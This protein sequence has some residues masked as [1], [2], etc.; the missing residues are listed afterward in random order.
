MENYFFPLT[1]MQQNSFEHTIV[2]L[3]NIKFQ[4]NPSI[5]GVGEVTDRQTEFIITLQLCW[6]VFKKITKLAR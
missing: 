4:G 5:T 3:T 6:K 1:I 2:N